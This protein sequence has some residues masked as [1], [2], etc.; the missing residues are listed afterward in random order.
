MGRPLPL[1]D[2]D[3]QAYLGRSRHGA[4][5]IIIHKMSADGTRLLDEGMTVYTGPVAEG[6]K[7]FKK[8]VTI[9]SLFRK[10]E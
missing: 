8:M 3:G 4:G 1:W 2:E 9:I 6:T 7:I 10:E 5:P